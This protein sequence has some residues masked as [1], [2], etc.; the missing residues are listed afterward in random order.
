MGSEVALRFSGRRLESEPARLPGLRERRL[1]LGSS[2]RAQ[3][4]DPLGR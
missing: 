2:E 1:G 3:C 4:P